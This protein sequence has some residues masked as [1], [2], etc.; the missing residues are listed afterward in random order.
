MPD[1]AET[2]IASSAICGLA[3]RLKLLSVLRATGHE[4]WIGRRKFHESA[5][6]VEVKDIVF[7]TA[8]LTR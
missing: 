2:K 5:S 4:R 6:D 1:M 8:V 3:A 7:F